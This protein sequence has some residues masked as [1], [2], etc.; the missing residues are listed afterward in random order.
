MR[1][2]LPVLPSNPRHEDLTAARVLTAY[3]DGLLRGARSNAS[4]G[5]TE[6][7][8][9]KVRRAIALRNAAR[10]LRAAVE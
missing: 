7:A 6:K 8:E 1:K 9:D 10:R 4:V 2:K 5:K 3:A